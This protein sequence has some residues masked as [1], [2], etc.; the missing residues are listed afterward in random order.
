MFGVGG[1][2]FSDWKWKTG[3]QVDLVTGRKAVRFSDGA[4]RPERPR[5][6]SLQKIRNGSSLSDSDDWWR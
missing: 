6:K 5:Q 2:R 1:G 4:V 3:E